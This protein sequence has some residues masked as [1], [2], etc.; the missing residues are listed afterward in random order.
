MA[1]SRLPIRVRATHV[2]DGNLVEAHSVFCPSRQ[3]SIPLDECLCCAHCTGAAVDPKDGRYFLTCA[4][5]MV[6]AVPD[7]PASFAG[8]RPLPLEAKRADQTPVSAIM[9]TPVQ[10]VSP[11]LSVE[12]LTI[13]LLEGNFSGAPVVDAKGKLVGMVSKTDLLRQSSDA[14]GNLDT[15]P[16]VLRS[17]QGVEYELGPGF[18]LDRIA[19]ATVEEIMAPLAFSIPETAP[20]A[21]AAALMAFEGIHRLPVVGSEGEVVGLV[22]SLDVLRFVAEQTGYLRSRA[23]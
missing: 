23:R 15:E 10:C 9:A 8:A 20:I 18:H 22:S 14:D 16:L 7:E 5:P 4:P 13:L 6:P 21:Q 11:E 12:Q 2:G 19:Q 17:K 3:S 1:L